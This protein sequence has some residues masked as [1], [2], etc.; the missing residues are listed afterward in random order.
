MEPFCRFCARRKQYVAAEI[1]DHI[2]P[3][4]GNWEAFRIGELQSLCIHC[5]NSEK[6]FEEHR[7]FV[8]GIGLDGMPIDPNHPVYGGWCRN[9]R[10]A[11]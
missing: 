10:L 7:G 11:G 5:H 3:H 1:A 6:K 8:K 2:V 4:K 9:T